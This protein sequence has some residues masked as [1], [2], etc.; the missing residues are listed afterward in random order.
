MSRIS[1]VLLLS[2]LST[3]VARPVMA[4]FPWL[5]IDANH[6]AILFF[7]EN[8]SERN[9]KLPGPVAQT[10]VSVLNAE[11]RLAAVKLQA[12][13]SDSFVGMASIDQVVPDAT[14][15]SQTTYGIYQ[16]SLLQ[17][18]T[19]HRGGK[20]PS[21]G[22]SPK[23]QAAIPWDLRAD[24]SHVDGAVE[25][26]VI[27]KGKPLVG[28]TVQLFC[29]EGH[30]EAARETDES[31]KVVFSDEEVEDG[32]NGILVG[33]TDPNESGSYQERTYESAAHYLTVTFTDPEDFDQA[34]P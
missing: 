9:Y 12:I 17:Y 26:H 33:Y 4:H 25:V 1:A 21:A 3:F 27:W 31:G 8:P 13:E 29:E 16:G 19:M 11:G 34:A 32:L 18:Y 14:L 7:G 28:A 20:L 24:L 23:N 15:V 5:A 30:E 2:L 6:T 10:D 22:E